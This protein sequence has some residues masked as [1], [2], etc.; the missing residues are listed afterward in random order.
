M[1]ISYSLILKEAW[2]I[3]I[4]NKILWIFGLFASFISLEAVYEV[5]ISQYHQ[6]KNIESLYQKILG[7]AENQSLLIGKYVYFFNVLATDYLSYIFFI[8]TAVLVILFIWLVFTS[9]IAIILSAAKIYQKKKTTANEI[10]ANSQGKFWPVLGLN[11]IIK[12]GLYAGF[13]IIGLPLLYAL[14]AQSQQSIIIANLFFLIIYTVFAV[15]VSFLA[16]YATNFIVLKNTSIFEALKQAWQL[17]S[18]N[19]S[20][21]MELAFILFFL[22]ICSLI[23]ILCLFFLAFVPLFA[24]LL[25]SLASASLIGIIMSITLLILAFLIIALLVNSI[26]TVFYLSSWTIAFIQLTETS[27]LSQI[28]HLVKGLPNLFKKTAQKYNLE[29]DKKEIKK[30]AK[31]LAKK[32]KQEAAILS[33][34][35]GKEYIKIKPKAKKEIKI[36]AKK[37]KAAYE[38]MEPK[39]KK[40]IKKIVSQSKK[41][42]ITAKSGGRKPAASSPKRKTSKTKKTTKRQAAR[43]GKRK[44]KKT[45]K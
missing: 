11:I 26:F 28:M 43:K 12:I 17:F 32:T 23:L 22:K 13:L 30:E 36:L 33:Q 44:A 9:Q 3:A 31:K 27:L 34:K 18:K 25:L 39:I 45:K 29:I 2:Q 15:V 19:I 16:A 40:E 5:I 35:L 24:V 42:A 41:K 14:L 4:K 10:I 6:A 1:K 37:T 20:L 21:S 38:K 7:A 8:L